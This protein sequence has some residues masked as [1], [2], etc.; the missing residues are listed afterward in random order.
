MVSVA[1]GAVFGGNGSAGMATIAAGGSVQPGYNNAG[2]LS[3]TGLSFSGSGGIILGGLATSYT[4]SPAIAVNGGMST[5]GSDSITINIAGSLAGTPTGVYE[6]VGYSTMGGSGTAAFQLGTLPNRG[7]GRLTFPAGL[8]D[9]VLTGTDFLH[10][11]GA[12]SSQWNT[13]TA[14]WKLDSSGGAATYIDS[15]SPDTVVFDDDAGANSTVNIATAVYPTSVTFNNN[16]SSYV[17]QGASGIFGSTAL[18]LKGQGS[19]TIANSNGYSGGTGLGSGVLNLNAAQAIGSGALVVGG[20]TLNV[21]YS[22]SP[23]SV[24]LMGG[25]LNLANSAAIG[26]G[27]LTI[28]GGTLDNTSGAAMTL[29]GNN[30]QNWN[31]DFTFLGSSDLNVGTG[32][33]TLGSNRTVTVNANT[34]TVGGAIGDGGSGYSL[35]VAGSGAPCS[36][37]R[38]VSAGLRP[39]AVARCNSATARLV[40]TGPSTERPA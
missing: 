19:V 23:S 20:G 21:N 7:V 30:A 38:A 29:A 3:L 18:S 32:A 14:N 40:T 16:T 9:L 24:A 11:T 34:L 36:R 28:S 12:V 27:I 13:T 10:W 25:L 15:P 39:S 4:A 6:L 8:V 31:G 17:L 33:V 1:S 5:N 2:S 22:Q 37:L 35:S 26:S